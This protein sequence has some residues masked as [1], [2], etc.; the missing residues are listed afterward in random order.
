MCVDGVDV[1]ISVA[2]LLR[3]KHPRQMRDARVS[4]PTMRFLYRAQSR[5]CDRVMIDDDGF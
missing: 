3:A 4:F 5:S 1:S 2:V